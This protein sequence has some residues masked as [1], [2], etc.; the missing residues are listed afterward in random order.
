M[1]DD[2]NVLKQRD[3]AQTLERAAELY[4]ALEW[5]PEVAN[6][7]YDH[8]QITSVIF[9]G[10][11][12]SA[13]AADIAAHL[14]QT[15]LSIP[16]EVVRDYD[17]PRY[18]G[19]ETLV[20]AIS[21]SGNTEETVNCYEE[22]RQR[23]CQ[24]A[25]IAT[26]GKL[27]EKAIEHDVVNVTIPSGGQPRMAMFRHLRAIFHLL[28]HFEVTDNHFGNEL[29]EAA[30]WLKAESGSWHS[31]VPIHENYAKQF[32]LM[33]VG[34]SAAFYGG[35]L[36]APLAYKFKI[37]WNESS[38]NIAFSNEYP[39]FNHNEFIGWSSH[40][41]EKPFFIVD[42]ISDQ[43]RPRITERMELSDRLLS[44]IRPKS[45]EIHLRGET[46]LRQAVWACTFA[47]FASIYLAILN[48]VNPEPV[49]LVEKFKKELS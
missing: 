3:P 30:S 22:A 26:G 45:T 34:K 27:L 25:I 14:L 31:G 43:E 32:A 49:A 7:S 21:H 40:P 10:M 5:Q 16:V 20:F 28:E 47:D 12:G 19:A 23:N 24:I 29:R 44:G 17:L 1:L 42:L 35:P 2:I 37:S 41:V 46:Y 4:Q 13:L 36:T 48:N 11:G 33:A 8:R 6:G 18:A 38:K 39:E 9:A 15:Q